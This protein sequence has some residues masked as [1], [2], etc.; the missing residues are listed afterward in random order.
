[1]L[2][3]KKVHPVEVLAFLWLT[4]FLFSMTGTAMSLTFG[5][6]DINKWPLKFFIDLLLAS[7]LVSFL[8]MKWC[9][10]SDKMEKKTRL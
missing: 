7:L 1:M 4:C 9:K 5:W 6:G 2:K 10:R 3:M 8:I